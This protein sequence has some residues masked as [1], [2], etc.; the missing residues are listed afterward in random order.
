MQARRFV[1]SALMV[2]ALGALGSAALGEVKIEEKVADKEWYVTVDAI[3]KTI[4]EFE[5]FRDEACKTP[6]G[7]MV[8]FF[9]AGIV[10]GENP[11]L[12]EQCMVLTL[13]VEEYLS[14]SI[15]VR[16]TYKRPEVKGWQVNGKII[17]FIGSMTFQRSG[18]YAGRSYVM[19]TK[20]DD[21]YALP[22][23]GPYKFFLMKH[24]TAAKE[25]GG[26]RF[27]A[28][29]TGTDGGFLPYETRKDGNGVWKVWSASSFFT[30]VKEPPK[31][32]PKGP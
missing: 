10:Y 21:G 8:A 14:E 4:E 12:G 16:A 11:E 25:K 5:K 30:G 28:S 9:V 17:G 19:G 15:K 2:G 26:A 18:K 1:L 24:S 29:T 13:D 32:K 23:A 3:P 7:S 20:T 31:E 27:M 6:Q 22:A